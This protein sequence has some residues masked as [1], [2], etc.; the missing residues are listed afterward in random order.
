MEVGDQGRATQRHRD[1]HTH[2]VIHTEENRDTHMHHVHTEDH[3]PGALLQGGI[4]VHVFPVL[5]DQP[6]AKKMSSQGDR[7]SATALCTYT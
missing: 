5:S 6:D 7:D 3:V 1:Q 4:E 2:G